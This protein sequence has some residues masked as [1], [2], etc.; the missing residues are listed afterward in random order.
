MENFAYG[1][2]PYSS[3]RQLFVHPV[4]Q[5]SVVDALKDDKEYIVWGSSLGWLAFYGNLTYGLRTAG[6]ELL[7]SRVRIAKALTNKHKM[8]GI[9]FL[10]LDLLESD[11]SKAAIV[12][13]TSQCWDD[14]LHR[15]AAE[16]LRRELPVGAMVIDYK[17]TLGEIG[18]F[19]EPLLE[20]H[21]PVSWKAHQS[22]FGNEQQPYVEVVVKA[23]GEQPSSSTTP[24]PPLTA[25]Q[26]LKKGPEEQLKLQQARVAELARQEAA[27]LEA[28]TDHSRREYLLQ[29][30]DKSLADDRCSQVTK[31]MAEMILLE[32]K[33]TSSQFTNWDDRF[34][35]MKRRVDELSAQQSKILDSI[36]GLSA[37]LAAAKLITPQ[38]PLLKPKTSPPPSP[39]P[40]SPT[41]HGG[42]VHSSRS[43]T[44]S[45]KA[46]AKATY[47]AVTA[48]DRGPKISVPNKFRGDDPKTDVGDWAAG[49]RAYLR[50]F[51]CAEQ[52]KVATVLGLLEGPALK[53]ATSTYSSLQQSMEDWAF[54]LGV[55]RLLQ[56]LEDRFADKERARKAAD[57]IARLGQQRYSGTLQALFAELEQ[58]TSTPGLVMAPDDMLTS[59]CMAAPEKF[60]VAHYSAGYKDWRSFG[61]AALE[62]EAKLHVQAPTSDRRKGAFPRGNRRGKATL[63]HVGSASGSDT[64]SQPDVPSGGTGSAAETD[65]AAVVTQAVLGALQAQK[66]PSIFEFGAPVLFVPKGNGE[67]R[68]CID[69]RGLNK[70]TR[71]STE[72]LPRI[73]DL[74]DMVQGCTVFS[75]VDLQSGYHQIEMAEEDVYKT[76]FK[77]E[78]GTYEFLVMPFGLCNAPGTFQT[79]MHHIFRPYLDKFMVVY[80]DDI[81]VF[82]KT[83]R[84]HAEHLALVL[85]SL[86]DNQ[87]KINREKS[88][89]G[90]P[91]VIYLGHVI[92]GDGLAPEAAKIAATQEWPQPQTVRDV[93]S[94][95]GLAS[96]CR[97]FVRNFFAVV[98]PLTNDETF[99]PIVRNLQADPNSEPGYALSSDLLYTYSRGEERLCI[100]QDQRLRTLLMSEC[101]DARGH[102]GFLKSYAALSQ[103]FFWKEMRSDMLR[104]VDTCELCQRNKVQR[105]P[106]LG[107]LKPLPIPHGPAQSVSIDFTDLG[108][109]TPRGMRHVMVCVDRFSKYA[110][111]IPLS[112]VARIPAVRAAFSERWVTHHGPPTSIVSDRD[113]RFCSDEWQSYCKDY[114]RSR[115]DMTSGHHPEANGL[116]EVMNQVLFQ[117]LRPVIS[118]DQ[119]D[120]D[121]HLARAQI[122]YNMFVHS[123][124]GFSPY[125]L[126][127]GR[128]PRQPL[129]DIIDKAKLDL[130]P[131]TAELARRYRLDVERV[132]ANLFKAQ[133]AMIEQANPHRRPSPIRTGDHVWVANSELSREED[134]SP[135]LLPR[136]LGPWQVLDTVGADPFGPS[137][138]IDVPLHLRTYPVFHASKLLPFT[139]ADAFPDRPPQWGPPI[140]GKGYDVVAI[141][142]E[143]GTGPDRQYLVRFAFQPPSENRWFY[144][145]DLI[146]TA[147]SVV[148]RY[149]AA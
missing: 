13:L 62:M 42:S 56:A 57:R 29:Q 124:T 148:L 45:Q 69:Y 114:M 107:L 80:L 141:E 98:A 8:R 140:P 31:H 23:E 103:R 51:V 48:A 75:K 130:T 79:E 94:F 26:Q 11:L 38:L 77:T 134:I 121:L 4:V 102:F 25:T 135:K 1:S 136:Y 116:A 85:Q 128:E 110:E 97:K 104:Y 72:P 125:L 142:D 76:A 14:S 132:R 145:R 24:P 3:W 17:R 21:L 12:M 58:L 92:S 74:L 9:E 86:R 147:K 84:E 49:T 67:F 61:R 138:V 41:S 5:D 131:G 118:P 106:P 65:V 126:H 53:W 36:Q 63:T 137:Y 6:Y 10:T 37:Q 105:K 20:C 71:K 88:S 59:F 108:K 133:K 52:T 89:F 22:F 60:V 113:P 7:E 78:Y 44:P 123:S 70:I 95:M 87:Y 34:V 122:M 139:P 93:R 101:H 32:H 35:R 82:S 119:Q 27:E 99:G 28:A 68:M 144:R 47:A 96:Y 120:W 2:T 112:E 66:K 46:S 143:W 115:L 19:A 40:S 117:L 91:S 81:L 83:A 30:L 54:G 15:Q 111:F 90:V 146:K 149:E 127:W 50:G 73:D 43:S 100:R 33:I 16:K 39:P 18:T 55:D 64:D 129:D 109:T